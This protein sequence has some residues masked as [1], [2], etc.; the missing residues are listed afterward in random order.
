MTDRPYAA[1]DQGSPVDCLDVEEARRAGRSLGDAAR[2]H[3]D[4]CPVCALSAEGG[5]LPGFD[6]A[7]LFAA[8]EADVSS[9]R[10]PIGTLRALP[11]RLRAVLAL[12]VAALA[13]AGMNLRTRAD[14]LD[15]RSIL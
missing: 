3:A 6:T 9:D 5:S 10:G 11:T 14:V 4:A 8:V 1:E 15:T 13:A 7:T 12:A 2:A